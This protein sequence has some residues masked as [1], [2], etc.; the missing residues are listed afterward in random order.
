MSRFLFFHP[1]SFF[2]FSSFSSYTFCFHSISRNIRIHIHTLSNFKFKSK[3]TA[4]RKNV[5]NGF[6]FVSISTS[7]SH[8]TNS[9]PHYLFPAFSLQRKSATLSENKHPLHFAP[10]K[11]DAFSS[12]I[13]P[14]IQEKGRT[15]REYPESK[16]SAQG[17][18]TR[19]SIS[20]IL[21]SA[22]SEMPPPTL[23][24]LALFSTAQGV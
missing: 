11:S 12:R 14:C 17:Q 24:T 20:R 15:N 18:R 8:I 6:S 22:K 19:F 9:L 7:H 10:L 4:Y 3:R 5:E 21:P 13:R 1:Y 2:F 23:R 16:Q